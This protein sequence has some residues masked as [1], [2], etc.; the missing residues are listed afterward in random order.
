MNKPKGLLTHG[1]DGL[2]NLAAAYLATKVSQSLAFRPAP[3]HRLD[4]NTSGLLAISA[5]LR[6]AQ[7]FSAALAAGQLRK[8]YLALLDGQLDGEATWSNRLA[9]DSQSRQTRVTSDG[10]GQLATS[11]VTS[12]AS[13]ATHTLAHV[14]IESGRT[15]QIR[16]QCAAHGHPLS[17]DCK[18]GGSALP[19]GYLLHAWKLQ[20]PAGLEL[21]LPA[22]LV[23]PLPLAFR[24]AL[25]QQFDC[26]I[27]QNCP[28]L[29]D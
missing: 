9:R 29:L 26:I 16:V 4:R 13:T 22:T 25:A 28:F 23:A 1:P 11:R 14:V 27:E 8:S 17:G 20:F 10:H 24:Q 15:H 12:L 19:G 18:Y 5:S 21:A 7:L 6:G 3:L 2:D